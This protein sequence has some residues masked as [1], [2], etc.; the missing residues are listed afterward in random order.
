MQRSLIVRGIQN[1]KAESEA[2]KETSSQ[3]VAIHLEIL[4]SRFMLTKAF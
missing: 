3:M 1:T 4:L 2:T